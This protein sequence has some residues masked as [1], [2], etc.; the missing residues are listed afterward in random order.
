MIIDQEINQKM[1]T[2][3][4]FDMGVHIIT[5][6]GDSAKHSHIIIEH[7]GKKCSLF[8]SNVKKQLKVASGNLIIESIQ[9]VKTYD[10][11]V[12]VLTDLL[13]RI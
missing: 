8:Y 4:L 11:L 12:S 7:N 9:R 10:D 2:D 1:I 3:V 6:D 13:C 5:V